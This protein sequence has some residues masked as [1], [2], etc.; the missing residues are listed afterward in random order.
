ML[1][2]K[3]LVSPSTPDND[4][5]IKDIDYKKRFIVNENDSIVFLGFNNSDLLKDIFTSSNIV[6]CI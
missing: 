6:T 1:K 5:K 4:V 2:H 3:G